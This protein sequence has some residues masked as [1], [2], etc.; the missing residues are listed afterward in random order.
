MVWDQSS[1]DCQF[2]ELKFHVLAHIEGN[3]IDPLFKKKKINLIEQNLRK[4]SF[5]IFAPTVSSI[6]IARILNL[7]FLQLYLSLRAKFNL[8][9]SLGVTFFNCL[10]K[11]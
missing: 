2:W 9:L 1:Q 7:D 8:G 11:K 5:K 4:F 6:L 10:S 3:D